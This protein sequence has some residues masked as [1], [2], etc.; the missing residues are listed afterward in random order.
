MLPSAPDKDTQHTHAQQRR[1]G[2]CERRYDAHHK[3]DNNRQNRQQ[4]AENKRSTKSGNF[5][6]SDPGAVFLLFFQVRFAICGGGRVTNTQRAC[7]LFSASSIFIQM[8]WFIC[9]GMHWPYRTDC[10]YSIS[11]PAKGQF[12]KAN[13]N[14]SK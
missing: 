12:F 5:S 13:K 8:N 7:L 14:N 2:I 9:F 4:T 11:P 6:L 10:V 1:Y 3:T